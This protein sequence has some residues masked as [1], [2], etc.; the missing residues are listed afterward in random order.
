MGAPGC[1]ERLM[2]AGRLTCCALWP[3][4]EMLVG[5]K[6][7]LFMD[8]VCS[9]KTCQSL[10]AA[11]FTAWVLLL[12]VTWPCLLLLLPASTYSS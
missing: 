1:C 3:A 4:G 12:A 2:H 10:P 9:C 6:R 5:P 8:E 7:V 11:A